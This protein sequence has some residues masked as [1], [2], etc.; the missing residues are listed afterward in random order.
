MTVS[1]NDAP[2]AVQNRE[3][4]T[5]TAWH[6]GQYR[7]SSAP[8]WPQKRAS[9]DTGAEQAGHGPPRPKSTCPDWSEGIS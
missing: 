2:Q 8:H 5:T 4:S 3:P 6:D 1:A 7:G 9:G